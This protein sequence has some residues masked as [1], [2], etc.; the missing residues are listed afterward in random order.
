MSYSWPSVLGKLF[1]G[2]SL[3]TDQAA[4]AMEQIMDGQATSAQFGGFVGALRVKGETVDEIMG[5]VEIMRAKALRVEVEGPLVDTCGTGGDRSGTMNISTLA[6]LVVAGAGTRV[7]KHGNRAAS[8]RCGSA[9][10][11]EALGVKVDL[12]PEGVKACIEEAGIGFCFAPVFHPSMRFAGPL[13]GELGVPT[14]FN[15]LGPLTNPAGALHQALGVSDMAMA[16]RMAEVLRKLGSHHC[17]VIHGFDGLDEISL[18]EPS[19][20]WE[21]KDGHV[22]SW[23][24]NPQDFGLPRADTSEICGGS[25]EENAGIA[26]RILAGEPGPLRDVVVINAAAALIAADVADGFPAGIELARASLDSGSA[27]SALEQMVKVSN[28]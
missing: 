6:A 19:H 23:V 21:L 20:I 9:D 3:E 15:F 5:L 24:I 8:S 27:G 10:L 2:A 14:I 22:T 11:L 4:W 13:R 7:A 12:P 28:A 17:L 1:L 25:A 18:A 26:R 16:P